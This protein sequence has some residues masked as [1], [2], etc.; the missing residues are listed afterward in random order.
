MRSGLPLAGLLTA[1]AEDYEELTALR[2]HAHDPLPFAV[3]WLWKLHVIGLTERLWLGLS[4]GQLAR[5]LSAA[6]AALMTLQV[7]CQ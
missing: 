3:L 2:Q 7:S 5:S 6:H 4:P 1:A